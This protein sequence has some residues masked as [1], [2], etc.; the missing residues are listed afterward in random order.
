MTNFDIIEDGE[1]RTIINRGTMHVVEGHN[2]IG[3]CAFS[4]YGGSYGST[5]GIKWTPPSE[6]MRRKDAC[7]HCQNA[8]ERDYPELIENDAS[9][10][11]LVHTNN[12]CVQEFLPSLP[13]VEIVDVLPMQMIKVNAPARIMNIVEE[14]DYVERVESQ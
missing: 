5:S 4:G 7:G 1:L 3:P 12:G 8:L 11:F 13:D 9:T 10:Q 2:S 14:S 6:F